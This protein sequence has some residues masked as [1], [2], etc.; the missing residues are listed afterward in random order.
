[1]SAITLTAKRRKAR[2]AHSCEWCAT[3]IEVGEEHEYW[4]GVY[5]GEFSQQRMHLDCFIAAQ[6]SQDDYLQEYCGETWPHPRGGHCVA[7]AE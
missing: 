7:C 1:M 2:K 3:A 4:S 5:D 6:K